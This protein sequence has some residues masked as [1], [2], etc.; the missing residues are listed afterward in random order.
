MEKEN[1]ENVENKEQTTDEQTHTNTICNDNDID[2]RDIVFATSSK[3][4]LAIE[5]EDSEIG[6]GQLYTAE[7]RPR[8]ERRLHRGNRR[9]PPDMM[10]W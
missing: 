10:F 1:V 3:K 4:R 6:A 7:T 5:E 9:L 8:Y 2:I